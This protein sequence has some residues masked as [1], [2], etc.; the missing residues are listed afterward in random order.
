M[1]TEKI[2][3]PIMG[4]YPENEF[5]EN[6]Q[7]SSILYNPMR[8]VLIATIHIGAALVVYEAWN[9]MTI[10]YGP[11][12]AIAVLAAYFCGLSWKIPKAKYFDK[13]PSADGG[14]RR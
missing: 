4:E 6:E 13:K 10:G 8:F 7:R 14:E 12:P 2:P 5:G 9:W 11:H 3:D 1:S